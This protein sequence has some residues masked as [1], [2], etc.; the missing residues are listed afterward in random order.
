MGVHLACA[1][2]LLFIPDAEDKCNSRPKQGEPI[3]YDFGNSPGV[4]LRSLSSISRYAS[5]FMAS[6]N[7][8]Q[9]HCVQLYHSHGGVPCAT[10]STTNTFFEPMSKRRRGYPS[11]T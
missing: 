10:K 4:K 11:E 7:L 5:M 8:G 9:T 3:A 2:F 6:A 1:C